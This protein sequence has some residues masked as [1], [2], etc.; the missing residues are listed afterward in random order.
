MT[1]DFHYSL[2][3]FSPA[4]VNPA[5]T[6]V[7]APDHT[8]DDIRLV[9]HYRQQWRSIPSAYQS[10]PTPF[11][12]TSLS[13][14]YKL[15]I[16]ALLRRHYIGLGGN[17]YRDNTGDL[18]FGTQQGGA[19]I[20]YNISLN[21]AGTQY[22]TF[23]VQ[24][25]L[26]KRSVDYNQ[27]FFDNQWS[28]SE[29]DPLR[30]TGE[31]FERDRFFYQDWAGGIS[32]HH[33]PDR[34]DQAHYTAGVALYHLNAPNQSFEKKTPYN[35]QLYRRFA[36]HIEARYPIH[37][38]WHLLPHL[39]YFRQGKVGEI[40]AGSYFQYHKNK[41]VSFKA[42]VA[43]RFVGSHRKAVA[44][45]AVTISYLFTYQAFEVG[46][47][48]DLT[49]SGL[50]PANRSRGAFEIVLI[51]HNRIHKVRTKYQRFKMYLPECPE[52]DN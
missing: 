41:D 29:F 52:H 4:Y 28:G 18:N 11:T 10:V 27:A 14:D 22:L 40:N 47:G 36:A 51:F 44:G 1:Q 5:L 25:N 21:R 7:F 33:R 8:Q 2:Y 30:P 46:F 43:Y 3:G 17:F 49:T 24:N 39:A 48:Y 12:T 20:S 37:P 16:P 34:R 42:G 15:R 32:F 26:V 50:S 13:G 19:S 9:A 31:N 23:G 38:H 45:D 6:G 35:L